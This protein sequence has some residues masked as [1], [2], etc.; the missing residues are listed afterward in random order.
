MA[1]W[2]LNAALE[3]GVTDIEIDILHSKVEPKELEIRPI[4]GHLNRLLE[5]I[6]TTL[7]SN[8]F[9]ADFIVEA[10]FKINIPESAKATRFF[11]CKAIVTDKDGRVYEGRNYT[12][13]AHETQFRVSKHH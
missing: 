11:S 4:T 5:T 9:Q 2:I 13:R 1:D 12:E 3:K 6:E 10:K 7:D 8:D